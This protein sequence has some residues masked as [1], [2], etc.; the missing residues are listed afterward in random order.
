MVRDDEILGL[1]PV[2]W[3][4]IG[5]GVL[6]LGSAFWQRRW[7]VAKLSMG[8]REKRFWPLVKSIA[9]RYGV[10]PALLMA[11]ARHESA[12]DPMA[13][14]TDPRDLAR[15]GSF[16]LVQMSLATARGLGYKGA[17][18]GLYDPEVNLA[19]GAKYM[20]QNATRVGRDPK[21][22]A[23]AHNSGRS[24]AKAPA[25]TRSDYVP[26]VMKFY[27][28]YRQQLATGQA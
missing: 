6:I 18:D 7:I 4:L 12:L 1:R 19:L 11:I 26:K 8:A 20:A 9:T 27:P 16:G 2:T 5:G 21:D 15:G 22:L 17:A 3:L 25:I 23:A 13:R 14:A 28:T 10:D 24:F